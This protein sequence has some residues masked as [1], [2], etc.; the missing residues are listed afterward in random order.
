ML[1]VVEDITELKAQAAHIEQLAFYDHLT[2][3]PN[4]RL[5]Y[6]RLQQALS[7]STR[8]HLYGAVLMLDLDNFKRINDTRG[9]DVGDRLLTEVALRIQSCVRQTDTVARLGGDEFIVML[10]DLSP[11]EAQA[12][13]HAE[14]VGKNP[15]SHQPALHAGKPASPQFRQHGLCLFLGQNATLDELLKRVDNAMYQP[16]AAAQC[17]ALYDPQIQASLETRIAL[18]PNCVTPCRAISS[19]CITRY[20]W[21][22]RKVSWVPNVA[23]LAAPQHGLVLPDQF[24]P[25]AEESGSSCRLA[26]GYWHSV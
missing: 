14:G 15:G 5:L 26:N 23:A 3:L 21:T 18:G 1:V 8:D 20:R 6:N 19:S 17:P 22:T 4:R 2:G 11:D 24:I 13:L 7:V 25:M 9:H 12:S 16:R 10:V